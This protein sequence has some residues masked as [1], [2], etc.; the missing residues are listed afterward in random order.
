MNVE[1]IKKDYLN[2][3]L[4]RKEI[5]KKHRIT[6][7]QLDY[8]RKKNKWASRKRATKL[9]KKLTKGG[10]QNNNQNAV[11]TGYYSKYRDLLSE[12]EKQMYDESVPDEVEMVLHAI[13]HQD[14][15][16]YRY[17]KKIKELEDKKKELTITSM[18]KNGTNVETEA[19]NTQI[20]I[21]RFNNTLLKVQDERRKEV[22]LLHKL[23][24]DNKGDKEVQ[25]DRVTIVNDL[26]EVQ[27]DDNIN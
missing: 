22:E 11:V 10:G 7:N 17:T 8:L 2:T 19:T 6:L 1:A 16:E 9:G 13:R 24:V 25:K 23:A 20:L 5:C 21:D 12:D 4:S 14:I 15:L 3:T 27:E 26:T 18:I